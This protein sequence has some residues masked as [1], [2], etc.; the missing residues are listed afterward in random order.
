[1][2]LHLHQQLLPSPAP[3]DTGQTINEGSNSNSESVIGSPRDC[4]TTGSFNS[5]CESDKMDGII[6]PPPPPTVTHIISHIISA[7]AGPDQTLGAANNGKPIP[8]QQTDTPGQTM[9][10][11]SESVGK[12]DIGSLK[13]C[14][15]TDPLNSICESISLAA[16]IDGANAP[17]PPPT[18]TPITSAPADTG[19]TIN[20]GSNSN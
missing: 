15:T 14:Q 16:T 2:L 19:Q 7:Q 1:M 3:A 5:T 8:D 20:N 18:I 10:G 9:N 4:Q 17:P 6:P 13:D 12:S 11:G